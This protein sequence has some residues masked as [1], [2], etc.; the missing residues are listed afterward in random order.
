MDVSLGQIVYSVAGRDAGKKFII[1]EIVDDNNVLV[2]DGDLRKIEKAKK[3]KT[4]HL[5]VTEKVILPLKEKL[6]NGDRVSNSE[7]RKALAQVDI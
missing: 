3:K 5:K 6:V 1:I 7:I 2:S 4:K